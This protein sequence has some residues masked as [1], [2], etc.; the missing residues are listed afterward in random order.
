MRLL[1][2]Y[3]DKGQARIKP[4]QPD[5]LS[6][7]TSKDDATVKSSEETTREKSEEVSPPLRFLRRIGQ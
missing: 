4:V 6:G 7:K 3:G 1:H 5:R 2:N